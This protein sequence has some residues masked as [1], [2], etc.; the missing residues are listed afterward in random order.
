MIYLDP[1]ARLRLR[2]GAEHL[3]ALGPCAT[4]ELLAEVGARIGGMPCILGLL[5]EYQQRLSSQMLRAIGAD[6]FAPR[7]LHVVLQ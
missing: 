2:R 3:H 4:A 7:P 1:L 5:R 6:R